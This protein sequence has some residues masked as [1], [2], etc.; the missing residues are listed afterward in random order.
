MKDIHEPLRT[1]FYS[2]IVGKGIICYEAGAVP[3]NAATP[4]IIIADMQGGEDSNKTSFGN[5]VQ[6]LFD[7]VTS[8]EKNKIGGSKMVDVLAGSLL[9][10]INSKVTFPMFNGLQIV[11]TK[12]LQDQKINGK[13]DTNRIYRR[14]IRVQQ[15]IMEV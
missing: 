15:L 12:I 2:L 13:S 14:L 8:F 3:D 1:L 6:T 11:T 5:R 4:Y 9:D 10:V 7:V